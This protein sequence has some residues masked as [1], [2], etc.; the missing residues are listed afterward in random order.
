[1]VEVQA[2]FRTPPGSPGPDGRP[3]DVEQGIAWTLRF[4]GGAIAHCTSAYDFA[5]VKRIQVMGERPSLSL[6]PA[7]EYARNRLVVRRK[8]GQEEPTLGESAE[9]FTGEI[10]AFAAA[11]REGREP[12]HG[13]AR[14]G[15]Q[16]VR[17][18]TLIYEAA[19]TGRTVAVPPL[20]A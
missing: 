14:D 16:D 20:D 13:S 7:T 18:M 1:M 10:D 15:L 2:T 6:D 3:I 4:P 17:L 19:R 9:Q 8:S 5:S 11:I 12:H